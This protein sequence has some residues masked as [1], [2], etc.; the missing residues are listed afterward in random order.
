MLPFSLAVKVPGP[1]VLIVA[2]FVPELV[3][4]MPTQIA[5][6]VDEP[7]AASIADTDW[8]VPTPNPHIGAPVM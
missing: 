1:I 7:Q 3:D 4:V 2:V 5:T 6:G 8:V